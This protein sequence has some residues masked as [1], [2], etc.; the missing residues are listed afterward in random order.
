[1]PREDHTRPPQPD[2]SVS[3]KRDPGE[4]RLVD[5]LERVEIR[6]PDDLLRALPQLPA[7][8]FSTRELASLLGCST[9]L[10]QRTAYCL[11]MVELI[12]P[13]GKRGPTPLHRPTGLRSLSLPAPRRARRLPRA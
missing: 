11:R 7:E 12:E 8:P 10:A 6:G 4:R 5:V 2:T 9:L 3:R 1:T 13:A